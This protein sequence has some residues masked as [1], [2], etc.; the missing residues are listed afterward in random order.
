M[1]ISQPSCE[2]Q[3]AHPPPG[4]SCACQVHAPSIARVIVRGELDLA[5]APQ[6]DDALSEA[7]SG[8]VAVI[9]DLSELTFM[10]SSGL[11]AILTA[12]ARMAAADC[13]LVLLKGC[14]QVQR[15]FEVTGVDRV[16][17]FVS[18]RD[19]RGLAMVRPS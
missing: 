6:L 16:L 5:S 1:S 4:F 12:R 18:V 10:D 13:R 3:S 19:A 7:A 15:I 2:S 8:S 17:E 9:L 14:R 11:H